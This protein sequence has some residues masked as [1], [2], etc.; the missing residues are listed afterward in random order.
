MKYSLPFKSQVDYILNENISL[1]HTNTPKNNRTYSTNNYVNITT[2]YDKNSSK[3]LHKDY[4]IFS[5]KS[6]PYSTIESK[7]ASQYAL[8]NYSQN[9]HS[10]NSPYIS[11]ESSSKDRI[12]SRLGNRP[13]ISISSRQPILNSFMKNM[14]EK[15]LTQNIWVLFS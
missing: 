5:R 8:P 14:S 6:N 9:T 7:K 10:S 13:N 15:N 12:E 4:P 11:K 3:T 1:R 2:N